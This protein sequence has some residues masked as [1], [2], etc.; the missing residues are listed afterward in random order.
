MENYFSFSFP[1]NLLPRNNECC[2]DDVFVFCDNRC[3]DEGGPGNYT[4]NMIYRLYLDAFY[5]QKAG[6]ASAQS[7]ILMA[8]M[9]V[10]T[11]VYF[12]FGERRVHYQ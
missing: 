2:D 3:H 8:I 9:I 4:T 11:I 6:V 5:F 10:V 7:I 1:D 12:T